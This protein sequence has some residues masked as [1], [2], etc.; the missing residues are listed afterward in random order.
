M[1]LFSIKVELHC[2]VACSQDDGSSQTRTYSQCFIG[3]RNDI[4]FQ[5]CI[6]RRESCSKSH[7]FTDMHLK[8]KAPWAFFAGIHK[9]F[10]LAS[11]NDAKKV[12]AVKAPTLLGFS[13]S[14][15]S[16]N[17]PLVVSFD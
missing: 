14:K 8:V 12:D 16:W 13:F 9:I 4:Y 15:G 5:R 1:S 11:H 7:K 3:R 2:R 17:N 6:W 10:P